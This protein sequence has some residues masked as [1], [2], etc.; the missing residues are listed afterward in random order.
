MS[1]ISIIVPVCNEIDN[2]ASLKF[3]LEKLVSAIEFDG[4]SVEIIV[5][6]N[7]STDGSVE[8]LSKWME[9]NSRVNCEFL[10]RNIGFQGSLILGMR[11]A[12]GDACVIF[13]SDLQD[14]P[15]LIL[16]M[17]EAWRLGAKLVSSQIIKRQEN[18]LDRTT[19]KIFYTILTKISDK[20]IMNAFQDF[21]LLDK[22]IYSEIAT[23]PLTD[24]F[25]R[26][27]IT[28]KYGFG[29][30]IKY[31]R[32]PRLNGNSK[33]N[34]A[35]K[36]NLALDALLLN[37]Q[38]FQRMYIISSLFI[39]LFVTAGALTILLIHFLGLEYGSKGWLSQVIITLS[40]F[41]FLSISFAYVIEYL[42]RIYRNLLEIQRKLYSLEKIIT[43]RKE[44]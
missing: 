6:D 4:N 39:S 27:E 40:V 36:W 5:N 41:S 34:F 32:K 18:I 16:E 26:S 7:N 30:I 21:Y 28:T 25:V 17:I 2:L 10:P 23:L 19:R 11:R 24:V 13:Q 42:S 8:Y 22:L 12:K 43:N 14:P 15:E 44:N 9:M 3:E 31:D 29:H 20:P 35:N 38:K 1:L 37:N 33:F